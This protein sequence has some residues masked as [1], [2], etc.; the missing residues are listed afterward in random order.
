MKLKISGKFQDNDDSLVNFE[1]LYE[2]VNQYQYWFRRAFEFLSTAPRINP[3]AIPKITT[4]GD[5]IVA[6]FLS[7][8][9]KTFASNISCSFSHIPEY[10]SLN[11]FLDIFNERLQEIYD[12]YQRS[13]EV[14]GFLT[15]YESTP[16]D[17]LDHTSS[18]KSSSSSAPRDVNA[19]FYTP[20]S[21]DGRNLDYLPNDGDPPGGFR[22]VNALDSTTHTNP[23]VKQVYGCFTIMAAFGRCTSSYCKK[24]H[25]GE[26]LIAAA[27]YWYDLLKNSRYNTLLHASGNHN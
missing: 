1:Y 14:V 22:D 10:A 3:K 25:K 7:R 12:N 5:G 4:R 16:D 17:S 15:R 6:I 26:D 20:G 18:R 11:D 23:P 21:L 9:P 13:K 24:S 8:L 27:H 2:A 19:I